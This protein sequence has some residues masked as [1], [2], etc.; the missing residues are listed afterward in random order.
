MPE[1]VDVLDI[2]SEYLRELFKALLSKLQVRFGQSLQPEDI[3]Y[4]M[5]V[6]A[7]WSETAKQRMR[8][9]AVQAGLISS[10]EINMPRL[11]LVLEPEAAAVYCCKRATEAHMRSGDTFMVVDAGGGTVDIVVQKWSAGVANQRLSELARGEGD[12]CGSTFLDTRFLEWL[13]SKVG[14]DAMATVKTERG[15]EYMQRK[16]FKFPLAVT[17]MRVF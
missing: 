9:C 5:T 14:T 8:Q 2:V 6:P 4:C 17:Q 12:W 13:S 16:I 7:I 11:T 10:T 15:H 1:G 3:H